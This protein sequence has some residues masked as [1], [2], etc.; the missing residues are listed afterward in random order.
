MSDPR[1]GTALPG[2]HGAGPGRWVRMGRAAT[3]RLLELRVGAQGFCFQ[4][5]SEEFC[6]P[7]DSDEQTRAEG[8]K[9]SPAVKPN[10]LSSRPG[11]ISWCLRLPG[12]RARQ[13]GE[14]TFLLIK[15]VPGLG[16]TLGA[17]LPFLCW[18]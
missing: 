4:A 6:L 16:E 3:G 9:R 15:E 7:S 8:S 17:T 5:R 10:L 14:G 18:L 13:E 12:P 11:G 1:A 2:L